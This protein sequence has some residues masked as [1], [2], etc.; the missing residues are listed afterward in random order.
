MN[1]DSIKSEI[2]PAAS[3]LLERILLVDDEPA[4]LSAYKKVFRKQWNL[5]TASGGVEALE[6]LAREEPFAVVISDLTMPG[7]NGIRLL[8]EVRALVPDTVRIML[9][10]RADIDSVIEAVNR[11]GLF[12][13]LVKPVAIDDMITAVEAGL[14]QYR[15]IKTLERTQ[16]ELRRNNAAKDRF[17]SILAHDLR[18]PLHEIIFSSEYLVEKAPLVTPERRASTIEGIQRASRR[19][20][21]LLENLLAWSRL[22]RGALEPNLRTFELK[23]LVINEIGLIKPQAVHKGVNIEIDIPDDFLVFSDPNLIA[24]VLRNLVSNA[25]KFTARDG[26]VLISAEESD[27]KRLIQ[28]ADSGQGIAPERIPTLF[29]KGLSTP[30]TS[31]EKGTGLGLALCDELTRMAG[32][33]LS[34]DSE[35]GEGSTFSIALPPIPASNDAF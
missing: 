18:N 19:I 32:G 13:F 24:A 6:I 34:V 35:L 20:S 30:G 5:T 26:V 15:M 11:A 3:N 25:V 27:T 9:T 2:I 10:G 7:M 31:Q 14:A 23:P 29:S 12:R 21:D 8:E 22:Q 33:V 17:I 16:D 4:V 1:P 28:I